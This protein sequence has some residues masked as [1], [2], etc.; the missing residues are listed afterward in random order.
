MCVAIRRNQVFHKGSK[1]MGVTGRETGAL[2][3]VVHNL[4]GAES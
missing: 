4:S 3:N 2:K 1:E